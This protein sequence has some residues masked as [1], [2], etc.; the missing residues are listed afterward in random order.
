MVYKLKKSH[1]IALGHPVALLFFYDIMNRAYF[2][3]SK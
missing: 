2:T 3:S 1:R